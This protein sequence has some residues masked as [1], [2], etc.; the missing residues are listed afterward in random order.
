VAVICAQLAA[1][2]RGVA[3]FDHVV[4]ERNDMDLETFV[5]TTL[6][7]IARGI[8]RAQNE[9]GSTGAWINPSGQLSTAGGSRLISVDTDAHAYLEDV[10]FDIAVTA[11]DEQKAGVGAG[12]R[13][14]G[15]AQ[16]GAKGETRYQNAAVSRVQF[17]V[18]VAWPPARNSELEQK[19]KVQ[20][21]RAARGPKRSSW[22]GDF[23]R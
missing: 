10:E 22:V 16:L 20:R 6:A 11:A 3:G 5:A 8:Q 13:V 14:I 9:A 4:W 17:R 15:L 21:T 7:Q 2:R 18:K 19:R 12:V 23:S 1:W